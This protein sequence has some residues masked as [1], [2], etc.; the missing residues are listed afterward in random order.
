MRSQGTYADLLQD[1]E[2][3]RT[4]ARL[5]SE[6][7]DKG[8][9]GNFF[10]GILL[11]AGRHVQLDLIAKKISGFLPIFSSDFQAPPSESQKCL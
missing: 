9:W 5:E 3:A 7:M 11:R 6:E 8:V 2:T 10:F 4:I 1:E